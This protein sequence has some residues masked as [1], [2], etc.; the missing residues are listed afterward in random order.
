MKA[1]K[2]KQADDE[3]S[4]ASLQDKLAQAEKDLLDNE[5]DLKATTEDKEAAEDYLAKIKAGCD[6]ITSNFKERNASRKTEKAALNKAIGLIKGTPAYKT[7]VKAA[8][9]ESY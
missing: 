9:D 1:A 7:A 4:L 8:T 6:F 5:E 2:K 3:K